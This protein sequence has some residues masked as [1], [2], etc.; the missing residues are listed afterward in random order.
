MKRRD[1]K[2][3]LL[4]SKLMTEE[5]IAQL[6]KE[7]KESGKSLVRVIL[8]RKYLNE[9]QLLEF[10]ESE[11]DIPRVDLSSYLIDPSVIE[12][13]PANIAKKY[14]LVPLFKT[15]KTLSVAMIDPFDIQATDELRAR[16]RMQ[17]EVMA[18]TP[19]DIS[20]A[21][22]QYYG[23]SGA[24]EEVIQALGQPGKNAV[25]KEILEVAEDAPV[26]KL[27][28]LIMVQAMEERASDVHIDPHEDSVVV[29]YRVDGIMHEA[30]TSPLHLHAPMVARIKILSDLDIAESR[31]PQDGRM[32]FNYEG[33]QIDVRVSTYPSV[34]GEAVV[35]RLLDKQ[36]M[37]LSL[38]DLG[39]QD[40]NLKIFQEII[41]R[42]YGI[43]LVTGPTGSGKTTTLYATLNS[44]N[45]V[46]RNIITIED[47][48]EYELAGIRQAAVNVKAGLLFST[49]LRSM[50]RQDPD[51]IL[52]GEIRDLETA[53][54]AIEAALTGHL[55]FAT[56]HTNDAAGALT[57]LVE[58]G[59]EPFLVSS[60]TAAVIAQRL[61][62]TICPNCKTAYPIDPALL[63]Q[64]EFFKKNN[65][66]ELYKGK[67]CRQCHDR[68]YRGRLAIFEQLVLNNEIKDLV[69]EKTP[70]HVIKAAALKAGMHTLRE[71]GLLKTMQGKTTLD[72]VLRVTQLD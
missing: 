34:H 5:K 32:E 38:Q 6:V 25:K 4:Q 11:L 29:R 42:P 57:R 22:N 64:Y 2:E 65:V 63:E 45:S 68:G 16:T 40:E 35:M 37:I 39:F 46:D 9:K 55:V 69:L 61:V 43:I 13:V 72:E 66:K 50:L 56:L 70:S 23:I 30:S 31:L 60:A 19:S 33:R 21:L 44:I 53:R 71:D 36:A 47:P 7:S 24:L 67:G 26:S 49:A 54:I 59:V 15:G 58:M 52:V 12:L 62:R 14:G 17:V 27:V 51:I 3:A 18:A 10:F 1:I 20:A 28:S 41:K 48:V 8:V